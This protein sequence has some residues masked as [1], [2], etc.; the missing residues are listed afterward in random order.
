MSQAFIEAHAFT[1]HWEEKF[2]RQSAS[3][4]HDVSRHWLQ[5]LKAHY[6]RHDEEHYEATPLSNTLLTECM[7]KYFWTP[8][9]CQKLPLPLGL[10]LYDSAVHMGVPC[11]VK[12]L[13]E[14]CNIVGEAHLDVFAPLKM[15]GIVGKKTLGL[16]ADLA[17]C[18]LD[19]YTARMFI[20]RRAQ[21]YSTWA[22]K[23]TPLAELL[24]LWKARCQA[25]LEHVALLERE[26]P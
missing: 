6:L 18:N 25:L 8:L 19:F 10:T 24:P 2:F 21:K 16:C 12:L 26:A 15:D 1:T 4:K 7:Q 13:Q 3:I 11:A 9:R 17:E 14:C 20:R 22:H 23:N 5:E